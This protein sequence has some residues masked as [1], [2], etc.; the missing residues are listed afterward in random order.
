[1][2]EGQKVLARLHV[3]CET[4]SGRVDLH[5][6]GGDDSTV[7]SWWVGLYDSDDVLRRTWIA[8]GPD[9]GPRDLLRWLRPIVGHEVANK[10]V[11]MVFH[12]HGRPERE[13]ARL[14]ALR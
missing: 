8:D 11:N 5:L 7:S 10:L 13:R 12:A 9:P 2:V 14:V 3:V 4:A 6:Y 1:V